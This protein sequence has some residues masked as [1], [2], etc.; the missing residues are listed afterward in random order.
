MGAAADVRSRLDIAAALW[1]ARQALTQPRLHACRTDESTSSSDSSSAS[2]SRSS[3]PSDSDSAS[4][5]P[6]KRVKLNAGAQ[7]AGAGA[8]APAPMAKRAI[9]KRRLADDESS[10]APCGESA[11]DEGDSGSS[12][13]VRERA[14]KRKRGATG[15]AGKA[16]AQGKSA[17]K[18]AA[19]PGKKAR[20]REDAAAARADDAPEGK[21]GNVFEDE[22]LDGADVDMFDDFAGLVL[23]PDHAARP[24]WVMLDASE[25]Y[26]RI[27]LEA[28]SPLY[29]IAYD[30]LIAIAE[31]VRRA[32]FIQEYLL[33]D[34]SL[35]AAA[36]TGLQTSEIL[37]TLSVFSKVVLPDR[38]KAS[39]SGAIANFGS[40]RVVLRDNRQYLETE[41]RDVLQV[42]ED[43]Q[44]LREMRPANNDAVGVMAAPRPVLI[45]GLGS[46][47]PSQAPDA[48]DNPTIARALEALAQG[49]AQ[50][51]DLY[52]MV[53]G[54]R[55]YMEVASDR[56][57]EVRQRCGEIGYP[58]IEEYDFTNDQSLGN[59]AISLKPTTS[60]RPYQEIALR[61][62]F[63][64]GRAR[65][66]IIVLPCGAGKTL[67]GVTACSTLRKPTV[68]LCTSGVAV[69]QWRRQFLLWCNVDPSLIA[70]F[71]S[72][73]KDINPN[74]TVIITTYAMFAHHGKRSAHA[75]Q[76]MNYIT[77][78]E[79]GLLILD[80]VHVAPA[81]VF[82]TVMQKAKAHCKLGLTA[83]LVREDDL[84]E[85]LKFLIG[86][87][88]Y[89]ANWQDLANDNHI[90]RV[91]C[92]EV[93][94][95]MTPRF[96][97]AYLEATDRHR[98][99][100]Y[101]CNP[102]K[103]HATQYLC[104]YHEKRGDKILVFSDNIFA[105]EFYARELNAEMI[106]GKTPEK[107]RLDVFG[108]FQT[109][110]MLK[111]RAVNVICISKVGDNSIDLPEAN[112]VIQISAH[113]G[114]RRQE[115]QRLGRILRAKANMEGAFNAFFYSL[116]S[117][118]TQEMYYSSKRQQFL[119]DQGYAFKIVTGLPDLPT[120]RRALSTQR[121]QDE[122]LAKISAATPDAGDM[123][124][125][126]D[127]DDDVRRL[128]TGTGA[129]RVRAQVFRA[130]RSMATMS[131]GVGMRYAELAVVGR[132]GDD[133]VT[134][135]KAGQAVNPLFA[136][137]QR[138]M[139]KQRQREREAAAAAAEGPATRPLRRW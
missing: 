106:H 111:G 84:I 15:A 1:L 108:A 62:M 94:C 101:V 131:G 80:E 77:E 112:V 105:L 61:K 5:R 139:A 125:V 132:G 63:S 117:R 6:I 124:I 91:Q 88:L 70:R 92:A 30:F 115:A 123:E 21:L 76:V 13:A 49:D 95:E 98:T 100:L 72:N 118:D 110:A 11:S 3:P 10:S 56:T 57:N 59:L 136:K 135:A 109:G 58:P 40:V 26:I 39:I 35:I 23:K 8:V 51:T 103:V 60:I 107:T 113:Y 16:G 25:R 37:R 52:G 78:R 83:T 50:G 69:E 12:A 99:L 87:K 7:G 9:K 42:L 85:K 114:S 66:G 134:R 96:Y 64:N 44:R 82:S 45:D 129:A 127:D 97:R 89:E 54:A 71:T 75:Q 53:T 28:F 34:M 41:R 102:R 27:F 90:A 79:W 138:E 19:A 31:P 73:M 93:W 33:T 128:E 122:L 120:E 48:E 121:E 14:L 133:L 46:A 47:G 24:L 55:F 137:R 36:S 32:R 65:S 29:K 104:D 116:V 67:V 43:D 38:L 17:K 22:L 68:V 126:Y 130:Q 74:A 81:E 20:R 18:G 119:V 86:P 2:S 4:P